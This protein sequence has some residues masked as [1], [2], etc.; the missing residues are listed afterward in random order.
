MLGALELQGLRQDWSPRARSIPRSA[1]SSG[2]RPFYADYNWTAHP[3]L[4]TKFGKGTTDKVKAALLALPK[5]LL[6]VFPR[7]AMIEAKDS[8]FDGIVN[9][10]KELG[11]LK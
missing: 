6:E 4:E 8:D 5:D 11:F 1:R 7:E 10:A 9:V 3:D 2:R